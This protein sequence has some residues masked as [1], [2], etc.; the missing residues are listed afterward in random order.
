MI[1]RNDIN[2]IYS[3]EVTG[4]NNT[5]WQVDYYDIED[6]RIK[7]ID[8]W[9]FMKVLIRKSHTNS[10]TQIRWEKLKKGNQLISLEPMTR[11][12]LVTY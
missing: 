12:E 11:I 10:H 2:E 8:L 1:K 5:P 9:K 3:F 4:Y 7:I 6:N